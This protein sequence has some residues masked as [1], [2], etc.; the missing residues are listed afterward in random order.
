M[1]T[2]GTINI[3]GTDYTVPIEVLDVLANLLHECNELNAKLEDIT[4]H[5]VLTNTPMRTIH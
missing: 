5:N 3:D 4:M 2:K 1:N